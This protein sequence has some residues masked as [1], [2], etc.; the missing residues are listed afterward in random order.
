MAEATSLTHRPDGGWAFDDAVTDCF[1][2]MLVRSIPG[3]E[4]MR[5]LCTDLAASY[6]GKGG[7]VVDVG[8]SRGGGLKPLLERFGQN[9]T[10]LAFDDSQA[11]VD[12]ARQELLPWINS[13]AAL[14]RRHDLRDGYPD[15]MADVTLSVLTL[16]FTPI[17]YRQ[18]LFA[19]IARHTRPGGAFIVVEK[20]LGESAEMND[21]QVALYHRLKMANGYSAE[22]IETK[23]RS[24]EGAMVPVTA[25]VNR[26]WLRAAGFDQVDCF[27]R[28]L[29]FAGFVAAKS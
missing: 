13:G 24:L 25:D 10:C 26:R 19:D 27:Y 17:E 12:A 15:V 8:C 3:Y 4:I 20:L 1:D 2:D 11:M 29:N 6:L 5:S 9:L 16:Q 7:V 18:R 28:Y 14:V 21:L 23:R 22:A